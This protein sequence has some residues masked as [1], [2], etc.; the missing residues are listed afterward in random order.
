MLDVQGEAMLEIDASKPGPALSAI[1]QMNALCDAWQRARD[2]VVDEEEYPSTFMV[3]SLQA[4]NGTDPEVLEANFLKSPISGPDQIKA[5]AE[6]CFR[7][8]LAHIYQ[9]L[10]TSA[11]DA[12]EVAWTHLLRANWWQGM[13]TGGM[14]ASSHRWNEIK[15]KVQDARHRE[16]NQIR[17]TAYGWLNE[18][19]DKL[20]L[21]NDDAAER[22]ANVVPMKLSTRIDYVKSWK[23]TR[24][25]QQK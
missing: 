17:E 9:A 7:I 11:T 8:A 21:T 3:P 19:F 23:K 18:H 24:Q 22:L 5:I 15:K 16:N 20:S 6:E 1:G 2:I 13:G 4:P 25:S 14:S 10:L 12:P